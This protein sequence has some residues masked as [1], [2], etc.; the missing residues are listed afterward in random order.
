MRELR[1]F[2]D[3]S[4]I[5]LIRDSYQEL[6]T[7]NPWDL[8]WS[9]IQHWFQEISTA[10]KIFTFLKQQW[11]RIHSLSFFYQFILPFKLHEI[12]E[13]YIYTRSTSIKMQRKQNVIIQ[14]LTKITC[15]FSFE[16]FKNRKNNLCSLF[17]YNYEQ[18]QFIKNKFTWFIDYA[19]I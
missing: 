6:V 1:W 15:V 18:Q 4:Q 19:L 2:L 9:D 11:Y 12:W 13:I 7:E 14:L 16:N 8:P 10:V 17:I 3:N 5:L